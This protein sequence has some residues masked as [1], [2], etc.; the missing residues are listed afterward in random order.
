[1]TPHT[2]LFDHAVDDGRPT[3]YFTH[4]RRTIMSLR[5]ISLTAM[6]LAGSTLGA[7]AQ[8]TQTVTFM[9]LDVTNF[10]GALEEFIAEF[11]AANPDVDIVA[12]FTPELF[13]QFLPLLQAD[14]LSDITFISSAAIVPFMASG[15]LAPLP[16][17]FAEEVRSVVYPAAVGP[18]S[19]GGEM[20]AVP[21]NYYPNSG[22]IMYNEALWEEAGLD[23]A[24]ATTWD[25]FMALA[26]GVTERDASGAMTQ[27]GFSAQQEPHTMFLAWLLQL[28]GKPFNEDGSA[29]F[30]SDAG[31]AALQLYADIFQKWQVDDYEFN[32]TITAFNQGQAAA[33]MVG[34]WYESI[35]A[36]DF[37]SIQVGHVVQPPLPGVDAGQPNN[38]AL[39]EVWSHVVSAEGAEKEGTQRFLEFLLR[40]E[41]SA[42]WSAFSGEMPAVIAASS[43]PEVTDTTYIKPYI[44]ALEYGVSENV[45]S[46]LSSDV[47]TAIGTMLESVARGQASVDDALATAEAEVNRLT[48]RMVK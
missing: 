27:A 22:I 35:L 10:R 17:D 36:K 9:A 19:R 13:N 11:E 20:F 30:N 15:R 47:N 25:E 46:Y 33:T 3:R 41:I 8:E 7:W 39:L 48:A 16:A 45:T 40:P 37:P 24:T 32:S 42:R 43:F 6:L 31:R 2:F 5:T 14:N 28:G 26:Q 1:M 21:Y 4:Q 34:P 23:P 44:A 29:A 12:N 38:W 18:V